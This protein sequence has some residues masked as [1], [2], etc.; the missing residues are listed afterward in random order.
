MPKVDENGF[1]LDR[2][3]MR[4]SSIPVTFAD[5]PWH[6]GVNYAPGSLRAYSE[7]DTT[8]FQGRA[9]IHSLNVPN[10]DSKWRFIGARIKAKLRYLSFDILDA[11]GDLR[12]LVGG[13]LS[14]VIMFFMIWAIVHVGGSGL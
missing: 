8:W 5:D 12:P 14:L 11:F 10:R 3:G 6:K 4:L 1:I 2:N 7:A 13:A 9:A